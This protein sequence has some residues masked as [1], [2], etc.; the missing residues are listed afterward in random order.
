M[1]L[2]MKQDS[3]KALGLVLETIHYWDRIERGHGTREDEILLRMLTP[4]IKFYTAEKGMEAVHR[5]IEIFGGNGCIED[6]PVA[7]MLRDSQILAIWEGTANILSLDLLRVMKKHRAHEIFLHVYGARL[8][9]ELG[10]EQRTSLKGS[11]ENLVALFQ[12]VDQGQDGVGGQRD[13]RT[14]GVRMA[15]FIQEFVWQKSK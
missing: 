12:S 13:C 14:L 3:A 1:I 2:D 7:K 6:F 8:E 15:E 5:A 10:M 9:K 4:V 11:W